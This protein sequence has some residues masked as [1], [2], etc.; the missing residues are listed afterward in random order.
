M[1]AHMKLT[2]AIV[3]ELLDYHPKTG[4]LIWRKRDR[5]WF[6]SDFTHTMWNARYAGKPALNIPHGGDRGTGGGYLHG[7]IF[8]KTYFAHRVAFLWMV[9]RW[10][11]PEVGHENHNRA[12]NRWSNLIEQTHL[13]NLHNQ[14]LRSTNTSGFVGV[15]PTPSGTYRAHI[16]VN[17]RQIHLGTFR[18]FRK[19]AAARRTAEKRYGFSKGHGCRLQSGIS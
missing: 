18:T 8:N 15:F 14:V 17:N 13:Q 1:A 16:V 5:K 7:G 11:D 12:D 2:Q 9:G 3:R 6:S 19:A 4:S 10:P